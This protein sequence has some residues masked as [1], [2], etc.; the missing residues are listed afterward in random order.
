MAIT[1][2]GVQILVGKEPPA[3]FQSAK[4]GRHRQPGM[5]REGR[6]GEKGQALHLPVRACRFLSGTRCRFCHTWRFYRN[7][8]VS[9]SPG[10]TEVRQTRHSAFLGFMARVGDLPQRGCVR[11]LGQ[12]G[13][14][15]VGVESR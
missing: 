3:L 5:T 15:P 14:N 1:C 12:R 4:A 2:A 13:R 6:R 10:L 7:A 8:V 9:Y 11:G